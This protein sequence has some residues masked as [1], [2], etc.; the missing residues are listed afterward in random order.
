MT[1][2]IPDWATGLEIASTDGTPTATTSLRPLSTPDRVAATVEGIKSEVVVFLT[3][4]GPRAIANECV[5]R[6]MPLEAA[7][8][9]SDHD[10]H[11]EG[12]TCIR[13]PF[14]GLIV[15][16][17]SGLACNTGRGV[18]IPTFAV[19]TRAAQPPGGNIA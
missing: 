6:G 3:D 11:A 9:L 10:K 16:L 14:H 12:T 13:C 18:P 4:D 5:H 2:E 8:L 19:H 17:D 7:E 15:S 1:E